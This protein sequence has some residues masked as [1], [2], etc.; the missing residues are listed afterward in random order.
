MKTFL[1]ALSIAVAANGS[2]GLYSSKPAL[3]ATV[4]RGEVVT[5]QFTP[6]VN[7]VDEHDVVV[8]FNAAPATIETVNG[9]GFDCTTFGT[10]ARCTRALFPANTTAGI[11]LTVRMPSGLGGFHIK[12]AG[13]ITAVS[14]STATWAPDVYVPQTFIVSDTGRSFANAI[15][16]ANVACTTTAPCEIEFDVAGTIG[17]FLPPIRAKKINLDA[18]NKIVLDGTGLVVNGSG[19]I[20][21][22]G[23]TIQNNEGAGILLIGDP[24][25]SFRATI[26]NNTLTGNLRGLMSYGT[27]FMYAHD[28]VI[29]GNRRSG[30]WIIDGYYPAVYEN[31]IEDNGASGVYFG[32]GCQFGMA[33]EN[34]I[35]R[36]RDFGVGIDPA[37]KW[38]EVRANSMKGNGQ[39][40][41]DY[42][43]DL[44]T[45]NVADD[46]TRA[47]PN[48]PVLSSA[49]YDPATN[50]TTIRG[51]VDLIKPASVGYYAPLVDIY[52]SSS[53]DAHG[54]AQGEELLY[55]RL[56][57]NVPVQLDRATGDFVYA[58]PGDLTGQF[59]TATYTRM[60]A[61]GKGQ[62]AP[63][64]YE[65]WQATS[66]FS[67]PVPV[68]R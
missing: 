44:V 59:I 53:L 63:Q 23:F 46:S 47:V 51:H 30:V 38:I 18:A 13:T 56:D 49:T 65:N 22:S 68:E 58:Y 9:L 36:N 48:A 43:L 1:F 24:R 8:E 37:A 66:E 6:F 60:Y 33:D 57:Y 21:I 14:G 25:T 3:G 12:V 62:P 26:Q 40:G 34:R 16:R 61:L 45:P 52:R 29:S 7:T 5:F 35:N 2:V 64:Y 4:K 28:N 19:E 20:A 10:I 27:S 54:M 67:N 41:I 17:G 32:P 11:T 31:T 50:K 55:N 15:E 42:N 39:L